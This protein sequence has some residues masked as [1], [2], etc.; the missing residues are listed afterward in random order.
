MGVGPGHQ[1]EEDEPNAPQPEEHEPN[2]PQ[3]EE[4]E[5]NPP[6]PEEDE[7][8]EPNQMSSLPFPLTKSLIH[9]VRCLVAGATNAKSAARMNAFGN[10][11][12]V[13]PRR[14]RL[15]S[16]YWE[17]WKAML[18]IWFVERKAFVEALRRGLHVNAKGFQVLG[19]ILLRGPRVKGSLNQLSLHGSSLQEV[20]DMLR[21]VGYKNS[22]RYPSEG[23]R[24]LKLKTSIARRM[25]EMMPRFNQTV[26]AYEGPLRA[27][28]NTAAERES[29]PPQSSTPLRDLY[30]AAGTPAAAK[31]REAWFTDRAVP[32]NRRTVL[33]SP[34]LERRFPSPS[35]ERRFPSP[36]LERRFPSPSLER[37]FPSPSLERR[38]PSLSLEPCVYCVK[39][40][41]I[42][43][44]DVDS[45]IDVPRSR[46]P[47]ITIKGQPAPSFSF[48]D[49]RMG[50]SMFPELTITVSEEGANE[51]NGANEENWKNGEPASSISHTLDSCRIQVSP[52]LDPDFE[53]VVLPDD[54][55]ASLGN[56]L[57]SELAADH[58]AVAGVE[59]VYS[60]EQVLRQIKYF[61][62][63]PS[64]YVDRKF[65]LVCSEMNRRFVSNE[66][67][68]TLKV[69]HP[70]P[71][72]EPLPPA[73][74]PQ[75]SA[76]AQQM[77]EIQ[78]AHAQIDRSH[79]A[80]L[81]PPKLYVGKRTNTSALA[82]AA[83]HTVTVIIVV[84]VG[85]LLFIVVLGVIRVKSTHRRGGVHEAIA[86]TEM[87]WDDSALNITVNPMEGPDKAVWDE[88]DPTE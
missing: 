5:P 10:P 87:A 58:I 35:L 80:E 6:Q 46:T 63:E 82:G 43:V 13:Q 88:I 40:H 44:P 76:Q 50:I 31:R 57:R 75:A 61:N 20:Q 4:D 18:C 11:C 54:L 66:Y 14:H 48:E 39:G 70:T 32:V 30:G 28:A 72:P 68:Q 33:P 67:T 7:Q 71:K 45:Y 79:H 78:V 81:S 84:C 8:N 59:K 74:L 42:S 73:D 56:G 15:K 49:F 25:D 77:P 51:L 3:P 17:Y 23:R 41:Q 34:S 85:F 27:R 21:Q 26:F 29:L 38:F 69:K 83:G 1:P 86:D 12:I 60:Y 2:A 47:I 9:L 24:P 19:R 53:T 22:R 36:S 52:P 16:V 62:K 37:R 65:V 64:L 55:L